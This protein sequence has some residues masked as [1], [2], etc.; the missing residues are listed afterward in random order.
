MRR[1]FQS[2]IRGAGRL[3]R[4]VWPMVAAACW[5]AAFAP[6]RAAEEEATV[7]AMRRAWA[8]RRAKIESLY[9]EIALEEYVVT[10][11]PGAR[12]KPAGPFAPPEP[13]SPKAKPTLTLEGNVRFWIARDKMALRLDPTWS[14]PDYSELGPSTRREMTFDGTV[15][16]HM[17]RAEVLSMGGIAREPWLSHTFSART[18][19]IHAPYVTG[20]RLSIDPTVGLEVA[21]MGFKASDI[22]SGQVNI[23]G[24]W[25]DAAG[26]RLLEIKLPTSTPERQNLLHVD[27]SRGYLPVR[28]E[29]KRREQ[30]MIL[31]TL[32]YVEDPDVGWR[33]AAW[34]ESNMNS[35]SSRDRTRHGAV[36]RFEVNRPIADEVFE[37]VFPEGTHVYELIAE[38]SNAHYVAGPGGVLEPISE[39]EFGL[40]IVQESTSDRRST[41][42]WFMAVT[43][44]VFA[45]CCI[46]VLVRR[47]TRR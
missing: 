34:T 7:E 43:L 46:F 45:V 5:L 14:D 1:E 19:L 4:W 21:G 3:F 9:C 23:K 2:M 31:V 41:G 32:T 15:A 42:R 18:E 30:T 12:Q 27:V 39:A 33:I 44:T 17:D 40:V 25:T 36:E 37:L 6:A 8:E 47:R 16:K 20:V 35:R 24:S 28:I 38:E 26:N 10:D 29:T 13:P 22:D 11:P